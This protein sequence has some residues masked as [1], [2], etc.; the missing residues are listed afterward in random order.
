ME[1][2]EPHE[3]D[4]N[5]IEAVV[6][7]N[8][9]LVNGAVIKL[10]LVKDVYV[11]GFLIPKGSFI[12][13]LVTLNGERLE[14]DISSVKNGNA[15]FP[16]KLQVYDMDGLHGIYITGAITR[17]VAKQSADNAT[18][19]VALNSLDPSVSAQVAGAGIEAANTLL[20]KKIKLV[21]VE[22]KAGYRVL[23]K[24]NNQQ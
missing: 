21:K 12:Y 24:D 5:A 18:Q 20:S 1:V 7:T 16:V 4:N 9:I 6:H 19:S 23:L 11:N 3:E 2:N 22:V 15:I 10:R 8:Q 17:D 13:G 14:V